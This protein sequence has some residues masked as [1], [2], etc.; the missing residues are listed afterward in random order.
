MKSQLNNDFLV[1]V[2]V[3]TKNEQKHIRRCLLS[4]KKQTYFFIE[5]IVVDNA[6][7]DQTRSIAKEYTSLVFD[8]GPERSAQRNYGMID[9]AKGKYVMFV[10]ADMIL[11]PCLIESCVRKIE[12]EQ[13]AALHISEVVLGIS[14]FS[15]VRRFE[16]SFYDGTVIDGAR[17]FLKDEFVEVGGFDEKMSGP[18]DWDIDKKI[19]QKKTISLLGKNQT[20]FTEDMSKWSIA[21]YIQNRGVIVSRH[22]NVIYHNETEFELKKYLSKKAYYAAS[23]DNYINKWG[24]KD[25]DIQKQ[26]GVIYRFFTVFLEQGKWKRTLSYFHLTMGVYFLRFLVGIKFLLRKGQV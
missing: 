10:D 25:I 2:V 24:Q 11:S 14:Y 9:I 5:I 15:R 12:S 20:H 1:S 26:L 3:T 23:F 18:E 19:K 21:D 16:R 8:K 13:C 6:S 4:I 7:T 22:E 17:F